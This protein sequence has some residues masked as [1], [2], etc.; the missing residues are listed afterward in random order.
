MSTIGTYLSDKKFQTKLAIGLLYLFHLS[1]I[2]G[3]ALG[4]TDW[5]ISKTALNLSLM[6]IFLILVYPLTQV[7]G[8]ALF[9]LYAI[10]GV[11]SEYLGVNYGLIFGSYNYGANLGPKI[12]GVPFAIGLNW[13]LL[14]LITGE[15]SQYLKAHRILK[16]LFGA[17]LMVFLDLFMEHSAPIFDFWTFEG[18]MAPLQNYLGWFAVAFVLHLVH[19][20][21]GLRG[22]RSFSFHCYLVQLLF[23]VYFYVS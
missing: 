10:V 18:G 7:K 3:S 8:L 23:F 9:V 6:G 13:A 5:F 15:L 16:A 4:Y 11:G 20:Y 17:G 21:S 14:V 1:A 12:G 2:I 22:S 19:Q